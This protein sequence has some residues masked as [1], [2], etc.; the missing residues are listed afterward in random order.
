MQ[1]TVQQSPNTF[2]K[3]KASKIKDYNF[4]MQMKCDN[5]NAIYGR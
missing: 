3:P 4:P 2:K 1:T 5:S